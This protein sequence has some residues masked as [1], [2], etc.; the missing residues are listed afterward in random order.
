MTLSEAIAARRSVREYADK[1]VAR[2]DLEKLLAAAVQAPSAMNSQAWAFG[3]LQG[4]KK[5]AELGE[6]ARLALLAHLDKTGQT[7]DF[8]DR[9]ADPGLAM[10][11][12]A[13]A[14]IIIY[15]TAQDMFAPLNC[16]LAAENL[17]LAATELGLGTCWIGL[18]QAL[19]A[20]D[21]SKKE[22]GVPEDYAMIAPIIVGHPAGE[23]P[24][25]EKNP[26]KVL[27]WQ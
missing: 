16:S 5:V 8:R 18:A 7:G 17:M 27:F 23:T 22:F 10:F 19:L 20:D 6:R 1:P 15:A 26:P 12:G 24:V 14:L 3:V 25:K 2:E 9:M 4:R 13:P 21:E 11:Y